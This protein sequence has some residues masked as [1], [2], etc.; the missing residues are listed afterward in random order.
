M[1]YSSIQ[2]LKIKNGFLVIIPE[3]IEMPDF[4]VMAREFKKEL[5]GDDILNSIDT[6]NK[7]P[8]DEINI[9]VLNN[10]YQFPDWKSCSDFLNYIM[11]QN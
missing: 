11:T 1:N 10:H 7:Q 6:Q 3:Q 8:Q 4:R 9:P 5:H 2:I